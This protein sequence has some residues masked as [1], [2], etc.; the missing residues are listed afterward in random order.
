MNVITK[1]NKFDDILNKTLS[2]TNNERT[3]FANRTLHKRVQTGQPDTNLPTNAV[4]AAVA[5]LDV[6]HRTHAVAVFGTK[7]T[8]NEVNRLYQIGVEHA[9]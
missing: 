4:F 5:V 3:M 7:T 8:I 2:P 9:Y 6:Q 1:T